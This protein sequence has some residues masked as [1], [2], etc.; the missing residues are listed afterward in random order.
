MIAEAL[1]RHHRHGQDLRV[2]DLRQAMAPVPQRPHHRVDH[3]V[4][5]YNQVAVHVPSLR[6]SGAQATP[7]SAWRHMNGN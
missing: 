5:R 1:G 3:H 6:E 2:A 4:G 7:V